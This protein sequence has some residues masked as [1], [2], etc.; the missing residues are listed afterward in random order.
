M[1]SIRGILIDISGTLLIGNKACE[2]A[3]GGLKKLREA[4]ISFRFCT[5]TTKESRSAILKKLI[6]S[7]FDTNKNEII[8]TLSACRDLIISRKLRPLLL[9][10]E[11]ALEDFQGVP[12]EEPKDAVVI[13]LSPSNMRYDMLNKAFRILINNKNAPLIAL[14]KS[15]YFAESD[16][17]S[18][19]PGPFV[20]ALEYACEGVKA[21]VIG[22]P[23]KSFF[24]SALKDMNLLEKANHVVMIGDDIEQDLGGGAKELGLIRYLVKTGKYRSGDELRDPTIDG[25]F[26]NFGNFVDFILNNI[27][28]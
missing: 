28:K 27:K 12:T 11:D 17:L 24:E 19:G 4:G 23:E 10:E 5:N 20:S 8:T 3:I 21:I 6:D 7:G 22:K 9:L 13:G 14:H 26:D 15:K 18:L 25:V 1:N 16:G 2:G